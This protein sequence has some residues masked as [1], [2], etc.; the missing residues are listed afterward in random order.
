M[1]D[2]FLLGATNQT[3]YTL[4]SD[5]YPFEI[6][7]ISVKIK[8]RNRTITAWLLVTVHIIVIIYVRG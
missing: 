7:T 6:E 3:H 4:G 2:L 8:V 1:Q 5:T